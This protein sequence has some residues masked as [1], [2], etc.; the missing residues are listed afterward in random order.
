MAPQ[1]LDES[2]FETILRV[3][4]TRTGSDAVAIDG[5]PSYSS[6]NLVTPA[7]VPTDLYDGIEDRLRTTN[8]AIGGRE[9]LVVVGL[10][11]NGEHYAFFFSLEQLAMG[12]PRCSGC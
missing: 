9:Y 8:L 11:P 4:E 10:G 2:S 6:S 3:Y 7:D 1:T 5:D 12:W